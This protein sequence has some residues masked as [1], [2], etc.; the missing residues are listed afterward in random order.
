MLH[1]NIQKLMYQDYNLYSRSADIINSVITV[2]QQLL[3]NP[4][5]LYVS[6]LRGQKVNAILVGITEQMTLVPTLFNLIYFKQDNKV[7]QPNFFLVDPLSAHH[8][9]FL[10]AKT[11]HLFA[12]FQSISN[13][14]VNP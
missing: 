2:S 7:Q 5:A 8:A 1:R 9:P 11:V 12:R 4:S 10:K 6:T 13:V 14:K 3:T